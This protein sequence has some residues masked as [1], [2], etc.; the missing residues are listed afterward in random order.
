MWEK[1]GTIDVV[2]NNPKGKRFYNVEKYLKGKGMVCKK[3]NKK[4]IRCSK[5]ENLEKEKRIKICCAR[6]SSTGQQEDLERQKEV[7]MEKYPKYHLIENIGSVINLIKRGIIKIIELAIEGKIEELVI[8]HKDRLARFEYELIELLIEK[9][10]NGKITIINKKEE[11][12]PEEEMVKDVLQIMNAFVAKMNGRR[13]YKK[14][15]EK[16]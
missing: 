6:V 1:N 9:Y 8:V 4:E 15:I 3:L 12:E 5:I 13:K 11:V 7:S 2:R 14:K 10:S 16:E